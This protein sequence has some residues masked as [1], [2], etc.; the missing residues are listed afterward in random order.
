M[1][2]IGGL[3]RQSAFLFVNLGMESYYSYI[4]WLSIRAIDMGDMQQ[5]A[6]ERAVFSSAQTFKYITPFTS[7]YMSGN[8]WLKYHNSLN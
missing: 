8:I 2:F 6:N 5:D 3:F 7:I 4:T 1:G